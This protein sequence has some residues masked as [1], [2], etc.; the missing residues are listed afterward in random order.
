VKELVDSVLA[1]LK[2]GSQQLTANKNYCPFCHE[3]LPT[4]SAMYCPACGTILKGNQRELDQQR[5]L[6]L[7]EKADQAFEDEEWPDG[8]YLLIDALRLDPVNEET[9]RR[10][11]NARQQYRI[12]RR[13]EWAEEH[14]FS[15]N[16]EAALRNLRDIKQLRPEEEAVNELIDEIEQELYDKKN[17]K[18]RRMKLGK[19]VDTSLVVLF[20]LMMV[21]LLI[22]LVIAMFI[23][24]GS[25]L[26]L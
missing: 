2:N 13:Y 12:M 24:A 3:L 19:F 20:Y 23:L 15:R 17:G 10:L 8:I 6:Q 9:R 4:P 22:V 11:A 18:K 26:P 16:L 1:Q 5:I 7:Y 25:V 21:A 14:Y